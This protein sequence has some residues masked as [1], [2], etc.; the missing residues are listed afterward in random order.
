MGYVREHVLIAERAL[1]RPLP[2]KHP[3]HHVDGQT[4]RN[5]NDNLVLCESHQYHQLLEQRTPA[6]IACGDAS[7]RRCKFCHRYDR[8]DDISVSGTSAYHRSCNALYEKRR[9]QE[10]ER[11]IKAHHGGSL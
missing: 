10:A 8:Q 6:F 3:V 2:K 5:A 11:I 1:G 7:A 9:K 4:N